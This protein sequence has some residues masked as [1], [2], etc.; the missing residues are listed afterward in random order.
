[1][2]SS[3]V[4]DHIRANVPD[5][6]MGQFME[7]M[8]ARQQG[9]RSDY[10]DR[11][12]R[13]P[14]DIETFLND[15]Y[16]LGLEGQIYPEVMRCIKEMNDGTYVEVVLTGAIGTAKTTIALWTTA[17]QLYLLSCL[18]NPQESFG[19]DKAS[20]ILFIFQSINANLA[21]A[22]DYS[23]FRALIETS[24][25]FQEEFP[26][27][28]DIESELRFPNRI[29]VKPVSGQ[30][31]AAIG[32][33]V[34]GGIIDELNYM[35]VTEKS[36]QSIDGGTYDQAV[37]LYNSIARRRKS[38]FMTKGKLPGVLC[39]VSSKRYPGQ[40]TDLKEEEAKKEL[41]ETGNTSI[42]IY[43]KR[44]WEIMPPDKFLGE[45]FK[46]YIGDATHTPHVLENEREVMNYPDDMIMDV[47]IE[48]KSEFET[49]LMNAL[50]E[51]GGISTLATHPFMLNVEAVTNS[52]KSDM[53][54][55]VS[56]NDVDFQATS[57]MI[58]PR[59]IPNPQ[60]PRWVH[61]D[62]AVTGD[63]AGLCI[64]H[65][66]E[67]KKLTRG[68]E[69]AELLPDIHIDATLEVKPPKGGEINF[70]KIRGLIYKL[71]EYG[72]NIRWIS[73]DTFQSTDSQQTLGTKGFKTGVISMD[74]TTTPYDVLKTAIYDG[75]VSIPYHDKLRVELLSLER[76]QKKGK[77]DHPPNSSKDISDA[78]A[79][80]VYG[81]S[82]RKEVWIRHGISLRQVPASIR[83]SVDKAKMKETY[84]PELQVLQG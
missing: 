48:Y 79:G 77:I 41:R 5:Y 67:F 33:N 12:A 24:E 15:E 25:Y 58:Y 28:K 29:I 75:R 40:F 55:L 72:L 13:V 8:K 45:F 53:P 1:M 69:E 84:A 52:F 70:E 19:L 51:I 66:K 61:I 16:F 83:D 30:E 32:Q 71:K 57:L 4:M 78:L 27:D 17:Y 37:A 47:P 38:R 49:D 26:F 36:K 44:T 80:V 64:G 73:F 7:L 81:L 59:N 34:M 18:K 42:Y 20:E 39:L 50:R 82:T 2:Q 21:K 9:K 14:V 23:R 22:L 31:T 46:V 11:F 60:E 3:A 68:V 6:A 62:L 63:S 74:K 76:D 56:R 43:D 35:A 65:V 54:R 10:W